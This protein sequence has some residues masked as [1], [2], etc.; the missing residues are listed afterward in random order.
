MQRTLMLLIFAFLAFT[1]HLQVSVALSSQIKRDA[2]PDLYEASIAELQV[3]LEEG[4]FT[5]VDLVKVRRKKMRFTIVYSHDAY[6][7][8]GILR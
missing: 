3:G 1:V 6:F 2:L 8:Q 7:T 5:S 4:V